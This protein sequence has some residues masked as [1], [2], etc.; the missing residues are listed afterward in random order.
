MAAAKGSAGSK[1][2]KKWSKGKVQD[3]ANNSVIFNADTL[4]KL[5]KEVP[6]YKLITPSVLVDRLRINGSLARR[7]LRELEARGSIRLVSLH[8]SQLIY[9]RATAPVTAEA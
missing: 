2:K 1:N 3:K 8:N 6:T 9:T 5:E 4:A 7:A